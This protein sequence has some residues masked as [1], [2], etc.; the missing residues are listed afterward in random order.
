MSVRTWPGEVTAASPTPGP[1]IWSAPRWSISGLTGTESGRYPAAV[2]GGAVGG[3]ALYT[4]IVGPTAVTSYDNA[5]GRVRWRLATGPVPQA[6]RTDGRDAVRGRI[7][8]RVPGFGAGHRAAPDRPARPARRSSSGRWRDSRSPA[9]SAPRSTAWCCSP[10]GRGDR[11]RRHDRSVAVVHR[12]GGARGLPTRAAADLPDPG[13]NLIAVD[14]LTGQV[15]ATVSGSAVTGRRACTWSGTVW[16][17]GSTRAPNGDAW[18]YDIGAQRVTLAAAGLP[19]P[20][21]FVDLS[22]VGGSADPASNLVV[23]AAC[24]QLAPSSPARPEPIP[25]AQLPGHHVGARDGNDVAAALRIR[26]G[27]LRKR[28]ARPRRPRAPARP[29]VPARRRCLAPSRDAC[30]PNW[31]RS[32]C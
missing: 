11:V 31:S 3:S 6:W 16:R 28:P 13:S 1:G 4:V 17:S 22:G 27:Y 15:T 20:H 26:R 14:P 29:Q 18:G 7:R 21:Y 24:T 19:W 5:T 23:I 12:R 2:F 9:R 30:A 32:T 10:R 25:V 8:R